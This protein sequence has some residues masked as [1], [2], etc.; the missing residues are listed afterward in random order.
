[1]SDVTDQYTVRSKQVTSTSH[2][3]HLFVIRCPR[4]LSCYV[5]PDVSLTSADVRTQVTCRSWRS[6]GKYNSLKI[7]LILSLTRNGKWCGIRFYEKT[8]Y[9]SFTQL[10]L[11][12]WPIRN[13][14][15]VQFLRQTLPG[16][17]QAVGTKNIPS[18][19]SEAKHTGSGLLQS[20]VTWPLR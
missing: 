1:M 11:S 16:N 19:S 17:T 2:S 15:S 14:S 7:C 13:Y 4:H 18:V 8:T 12:N 20:S 3:E 6:C 9:R 5:R 10:H